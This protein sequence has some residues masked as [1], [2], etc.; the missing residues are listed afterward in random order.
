MNVH[1]KH[2]PADERGVVDDALRR[3][4]VTLIDPHPV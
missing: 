4:G 3:L 2:L 1:P